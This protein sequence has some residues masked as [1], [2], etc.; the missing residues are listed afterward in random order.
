ML[1]VS[2]YIF[3]LLQIVTC[4]GNSD[5]SNCTRYMCTLLHLAS[6]FLTDI[7]KSLIHVFFQVTDVNGVITVW[8]FLLDGCQ[9]CYYSLIF[10]RWRI[11]MVLLQ[12]DIF[13]GTDVSGVTTVWYFPGDG[14][15]S[16]VVLQFDIF[17]VT[18]VID[19][20]TVW[21][22]PGDG[23]QWCYYSLIFSR[24]QMSMLL[25][26]FDIFKVMNVNGVTTVWYFPGDGCQWYYY[27]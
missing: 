4:K 10:S 15:L 12:F 20:T 26:K 13:Q 24:E 8:Y 11:S 19:V 18:Y 22:F 9:W 27:S 21:Y 5:S 6:R 23:C 2:H 14:W 1:A 17:Q 7:G 3:F 25:L 16:M